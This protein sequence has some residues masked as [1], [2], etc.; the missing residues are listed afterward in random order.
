ML[1]GVAIELLFLIFTTNEAARKCFA[2]YPPCAEGD[3]D[4]RIT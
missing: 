3:I 4:K 2:R 1:V